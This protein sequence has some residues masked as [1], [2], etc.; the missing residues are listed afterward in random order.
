MTYKWEEF[1]IQG[2]ILYNY[3]INNFENMFDSDKIIKHFHIRPGLFEIGW[4]DADEINE[5]YGD[6]IQK[7]LIPWI[8]KEFETNRLFDKNKWKPFRDQDAFVDMYLGYRIMFPYK[9][10]Y[11]QLAIDD[12]CGD[13]IYCKNNENRTHFQLSLWGWKEENKERLQP[14]DNFLVS[15]DNIIP[16]W[17]WE[18]K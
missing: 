7:E 1:L 18:I 14:D 11:F 9:H 15:P 16:D 6:D 5:K 12:F 4:Y 8:R 3:M 13:C 17:Y 2:D 10:Y